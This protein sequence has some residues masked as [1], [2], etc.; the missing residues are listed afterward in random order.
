MISCSSDVL[1]DDGVRY[2]RLSP[3]PTVP[4]P[5]P[6]PHVTRTHVRYWRALVAAGVAADHQQVE[7]SHGCT[8]A[9]NSSARDRYL[10]KLRVALGLDEDEDVAL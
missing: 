9:A 1:R 6:Y 8:H 3:T 10:D 7:G 2:W 5:I 4:E